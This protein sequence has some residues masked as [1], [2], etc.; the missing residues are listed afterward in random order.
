MNPTDSGFP[1]V[2]F[3]EVC[4]H[5]KETTREG[6]SHAAVALAYVAIGEREKRGVNYF[7]F[8]WRVKMYVDL[9]N[10]I[11]LKK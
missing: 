11:N 6:E 10:S 2:V 8:W 3:L 9:T 1:E 5:G 4:S 7:V